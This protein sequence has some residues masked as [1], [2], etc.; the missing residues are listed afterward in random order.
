MNEEIWKDIPNFEGY[1]VSN[2][3]RVRTHNKITKTSH[4][5]ERKWKDRILKFK[6]TK[7]NA[8]KTGYRVDLWKDGKPYTMLVARLVGFTFY[9]KD[10]NDKS[11]TIDHLDCNRF[12]NRLDNLEIVSL[13]ENIQRAF[14]NGLH[15]TKKIKL[16]DKIKKEDIEFISMQK[17][18][19]YMNRGHSYI[20]KK[21]NQNIFEDDFYKWEVL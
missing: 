3:G 9:E 18:S 20:H 10:I 19:L 13:K 6:S 8:Y 5:G 1:Q 14:T 16:Y 2:F 15:H 7:Q 17:A 12:N 11:L 21:I 4:H